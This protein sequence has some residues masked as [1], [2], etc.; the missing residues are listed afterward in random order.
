MQ[1]LPIGT[2]RLVVSVVGT[3][4]EPKTSDE[5]RRPTG[6]TGIYEDWTMRQ[7]YLVVGTCHWRSGVIGIIVG[8]LKQGKK[9][10]TISSGI[11]ALQVNIPP[12][13]ALR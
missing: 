7:L 11:L 2:M 5:L 3:S 13:A 6:Y 10:M 12:F 9:S 4:G 8:A 1:L